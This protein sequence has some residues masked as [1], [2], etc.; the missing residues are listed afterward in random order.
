[1]ITTA[2]TAYR[3]SRTDAGYLVHRGSEYLGSVARDGRAWVISDTARGSIES[4]RYAT[5]IDAVDALSAL[6]RGAAAL[7]ALPTDDEVAE[8]EPAVQPLDADGMPPVGDPRWA[9]AARRR[10]AITAVHHLSPADAALA[11]ADELG[12]LSQCASCR[13]YSGHT[14]WCPRRH[15]EQPAAQPVLE[16]VV[17]SAPAI[18][19][20]TPADELDDRALWLQFMLEDR[21]LAGYDDDPN[22]PDDERH[23]VLTAAIA[24]RF[25]ADATEN[26][27][28]Y[29]T[30][31]HMSSD[32]LVTWARDQHAHLIA[33]ATGRLTPAWRREDDLHALVEHPGCDRCAELVEVAA[34]AVADSRVRAAVRTDGG[35]RASVVGDMAALRLVG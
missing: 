1:M 35:H 17:D 16:P 11:L 34:V 4:A 18:D 33:V 15:A 6:L 8:L 21:A 23:G 2:P 22:T 9:L 3:Y 20:V 10:V 30:A 24:A 7:D 5:R 25:G 27:A 13:Y 31:L 32:D 28:D 26:T 29:A 14:S 12:E 19:R